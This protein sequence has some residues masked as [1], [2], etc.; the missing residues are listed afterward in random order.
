ML[1]LQAH[2]N[3]KVLSSW[4][5]LAQKE[6]SQAGVSVFRVESDSKLKGPNTRK[7]SPDRQGKLCKTLEAHMGD[8]IVVAIGETDC[9]V[10]ILSNTLVLL[11]LFIILH[12][13]IRNQSAVT[14]RI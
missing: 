8:L 13:V 3:K 10:C 9:T 6:Y 4:E 2:I 5:E 14:R 11:I 1:L 12:L 7:I